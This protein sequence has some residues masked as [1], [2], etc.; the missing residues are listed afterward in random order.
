MPFD[1]VRESTLLTNLEQE[2]QEK[3]WQ[4]E[5]IDFEGFKKYLVE[6]VMEQ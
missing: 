3:R 2:G 4:E 5:R 1:E 6:V